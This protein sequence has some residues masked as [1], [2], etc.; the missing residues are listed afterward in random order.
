MKKYLS[1]LFRPSLQLRLFIFFSTVVALFSVFLYYYLSIQFKD[2]ILSAER[3]KS[4]NVSEFT[5]SSVSIPLRQHDTTGIRELFT[6]LRDHYG[7]QY[8]ALYNSDHALIAGFNA[9]SISGFHPLS[10]GEQSRVD[11]EHGLIRTQEIVRSDGKEI[12]I[13]QLGLSL[14]GAMKELESQRQDLAMISTVRVLFGSFLVFILTTIVLHP[15]NTMMK[16][17]SAV[18]KNDIFS[19]MELTGYEEIDRFVR[20]FNSM[21]G[22]LES[23]QSELHSV[24]RSLESRVSERTQDLQNEIV[25]H[26]STAVAL[27]E[28]E[29]RYRTIVEL[30]PDAIIIF[31]EKKFHFI[32]SAV[33]TVFKAESKDA[34]NER[35]LHDF[36]DMPHVGVFKEM[37]HQILNGTT[38]M[39][40]SEYP[41][42]RTDG[43]EFIAEVT[44][45]KLL[46]Q[47]KNAVQIVI[48][49]IS[50]RI[51]NERKR[52]ELEQQL[53]HVQKKE[54]IGTLSSG[55]A[56]DI[57]NI[58]GIIGTAI[59]KL[60]FLKNIDD[61]SL[62][63]TAEQISKA[64]ERGKAL[65]KQLLSFA[66]K[67][68]LNFDSTQVNGPVMEIVNVIQRTFPST[69][70]IEARL[71]ENLP[72]IRADNNQLH[73]ALLNLSLNSRDAIQ[74][75]GKI[76]IETSLKSVKG[77]DAVV[78]KPGD[79]ICIAVSDD[80]NGMSP[81]VLQKI[82]EPFFTTKNDGTGSGLG[83]AMVK[84][85]V[86]NHRG[87]IDVESSPGCGTTF[88]L[89]FP[90]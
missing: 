76:T 28:S 44:A 32:N 51:K 9:D 53:L 8:I 4:I 78:G 43:S 62:T 54:I 57:L 35:S 39:V 72:V 30:S 60:L 15:I 66:R 25:L 22:E 61:K 79:Y 3:V 33:L 85:I 77:P 20:S 71:T 70:I 13:L 89:Y 36:M 80:G 27:R 47:G 52:L 38:V 14:E 65:V 41:F 83:L 29:E 19:R 90:V 64:T 17:F 18:V 5:A 16:R 46:Y 42:R 7:I 21:V 40:H 58:L 73:Q 68:E 48:R 59:N 45:T 1:S 86:E 75:K 34:M 12:G 88:R 49:D 6:S 50:E 55:I 37:L 82:Y 31:V 56:H 10:A 69:I 63:D 26:K 81:E 11:L 84:G 2:Q 87:F 23:A 24:N 67:T 74:E